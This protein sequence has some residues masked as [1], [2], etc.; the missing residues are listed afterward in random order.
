MGII[1]ELNVVGYHGKFKHL[2]GTGE[3]NLNGD[4]S[5]NNIEWDKKGVGRFTSFRTGPDNNHRDYRILPA[6]ESPE[7]SEAINNAYNNTMEAFFQ[8]ISKL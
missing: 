6:D 2:G 4:K 7:C 3:F 5:F 1:K 8:E